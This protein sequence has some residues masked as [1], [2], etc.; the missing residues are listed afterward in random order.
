M[1]AMR[2]NVSP[3]RRLGASVGLV[4]DPGRIGE[5]LQSLVDLVEDS[6][7]V[8]QPVVDGPHVRA[9]GQVQC[10]ECHPQIA[11]DDASRAQG[12]PD[13]V[14]RNTLDEALAG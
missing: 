8:I 12:A 14:T 5:A 13:G 2:L 4:R 11:I 9:R 7:Q 10:P 6:L 1:K 3:T